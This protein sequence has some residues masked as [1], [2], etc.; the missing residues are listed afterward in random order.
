MFTVRAHSLIPLPCTSQLSNG[1]ILAAEEAPRN[2][3]FNPCEWK[4]ADCPVFMR[5][6]RARIL[7]ASGELRE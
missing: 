4:S 5:A 3:E 6:L 7:L 2:V 1:T